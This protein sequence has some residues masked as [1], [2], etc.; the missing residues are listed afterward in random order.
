MIIKNINARRE[1]IDEN[2]PESKEVLI[3]YNEFWQEITRGEEVINTEFAYCEWESIFF[4][5][6]PNAK[7]EC[8]IFVTLSSL[9]D[10]INNYKKDEQK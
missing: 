3:L 8:D 10:F 5:A 2:N 1:R 4:M 6:I 7:Q 9:K